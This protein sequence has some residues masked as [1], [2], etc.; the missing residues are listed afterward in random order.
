MIAFLIHGIQKDL[1]IPERYYAYI[2]DSENEEVID[3]TNKI[4]K[5]LSKNT[6]LNIDIIDHTAIRHDMDIDTI[7]DCTEDCEQFFSVPNEI[8]EMILQ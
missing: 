4:M 8:A 2:L 6:L 7:L 5:T 1:P 3:H